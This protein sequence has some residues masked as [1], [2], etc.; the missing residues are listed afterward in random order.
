[1]VQGNYKQ[2]N[3]NMHKTVGD[4]S[5]YYAKSRSGHYDVEEEKN[6]HKTIEDHSRFRYP[7]MIGE[8]A[9][10]PDNSS[11]EIT[12]SS[13][14][15]HAFLYET[16]YYF[17]TIISNQPFF[18]SLQSQSLGPN[19]VL[20]QQVQDLLLLNRLDLFAAYTQSTLDNHSHLNDS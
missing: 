13:D 2:S 19:H 12:L 9:W 18:R 7:D 8:F 15:R 1:M 17:R 3:K 6:L 14:C 16:N 20:V 11:K 5:Q 10:D 4:Q